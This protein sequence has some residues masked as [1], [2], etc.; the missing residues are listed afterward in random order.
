MGNPCAD[1]DGYRQYVVVTLQQLKVCLE[2]RGGGER[3]ETKKK[4]GNAE[5]DEKIPCFFVELLGE[6]YY[7][8]DGN[9]LE[10]K[11]AFFAIVFEMLPDLE[12]VSH[13]FI[14]CLIKTERSHFLISLSHPL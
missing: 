3:G 13:I 12:K 8:K 7:F 6:I 5:K 4:A 9:I 11:I 1:F 10:N 14:H 2:K